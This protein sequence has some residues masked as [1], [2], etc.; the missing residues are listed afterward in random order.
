[1]RVAL[2][3][4]GLVFGTALPCRG[5]GLTQTQTR[6]SQGNIH[7]TIKLNGVTKTVI[8]RPQN[9]GWTAWDTTE[10]TV[11]D[12]TGRTLSTFSQTMQGGVDKRTITT[13]LTNARG[14]RTTVVEQWQ[15]GL[16]QVRQQ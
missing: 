7:T 8:N 2:L 10:R 15:N 11:D 16:R 13:V 6:D 4:L 9:A 14:Q 12:R 3:T 5:A 1:M